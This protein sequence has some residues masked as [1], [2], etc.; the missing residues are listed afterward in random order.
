M[1]KLAYIF[2]LLLGGCVAI[3]NQKLS[4]S[5]Q[6][7]KDIYEHIA[8]PEDL[9]AE[10]GEPQQIF[11]HEGQQVYEYRYIRVTGL[12]DDEYSGKSQHYNLDYIYIYF[13]EGILTKV[14]NISRRG[15]YPPDNVFAPYL[16]IKKDS[17]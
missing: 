12:P 3:G 1:N 4:N 15:K 14:E 9:V 11:M 2:L 6:V 16:K 17:E 8:S 5:E 7:R 13:D 10:Y